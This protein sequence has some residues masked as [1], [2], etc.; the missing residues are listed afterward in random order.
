[1]P[2]HRLSVSKLLLAEQDPSPVPQ[3]SGPY[4]K[5]MSAVDL[6]QRL[7][8]WQQGFAAKDASA[9]FRRKQRFGDR[10]IGGQ[11]RV[12][13]EQAGI[14]QGSGFQGRIKTG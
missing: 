10:Q 14:I 2:V 11:R 12:M 7:H 3:L 9:L 5:L 1:M 13:P 4:A 8:A 6:C